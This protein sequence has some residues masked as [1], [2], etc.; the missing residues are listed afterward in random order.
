M[1]ISRSRDERTVLD[2][3]TEIAIV[4]HLLRN[5]YD[6]SAP[7]GMTTGQFGI[8]THFIRS[9]KSREKLSLLA[10]AFQ[11]SEDYMAEK[12]ASLVTRGLLASAP[13]NQDIWVEI[14]DAGR[15]MHGQA[16][17]EIGPEVEQLLEGIDLDDLQT[18]L[19]VVQDI[20]R[21]LDNLPDR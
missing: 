14:T 8:L 17:S 11:D 3:F 9:G 16:L 10:W 1:P 6:R 15:E 13:S 21:T 12:V 18:S 2:L 20:R 5:R 4:E 19:R 7:A